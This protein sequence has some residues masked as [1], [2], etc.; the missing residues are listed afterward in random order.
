MSDQLPDTSRLLHDLEHSAELRRQRVTAGQ[1]DPHLALLREWQANRLAR[2][3]ADFLADKQYGLACRFFVSDVYAA[4][5][6]SQ[7]DHDIEQIYAYLRRVVPAS[8][9][10][11]VTD[12]VEANRLSRALDEKLLRAL[13]DRLGMTDTLTPALYAEGYRI[14]NNYAERKC[15]IE[16]VTRIIEQVGA[17][18]HSPLVGIAMRVV[19]APAY[20]A[21][22]SELYEF[23]ERGY[24]A[25]KSIRDAGKFARTI[26]KREMRILE[27]IFAGSSDP[28][29]I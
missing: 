10:Q 4:R 17:G 6:F 20:R 15:Q 16:L 21:G 8:M 3:Y 28:F 24:A 25:F 12:S 11:L 18:V 26:R 2:T 7:R 19:R 9:L 23:L 27:R 1:L 5:D 29:D 13:V 14:C 22:W